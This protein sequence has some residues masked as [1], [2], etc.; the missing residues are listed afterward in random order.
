MKNKFMVIIIAS[1]LTV[2]GISVAYATGRDNST[3][4]DFNRQIMRSQ[5]SNSKSSYNYISSMMGDD[6]VIGVKSNGSYE[7]MIKTM[8]DNGFSDEAKAMGNRDFSSMDN[9]MNNISDNDYQKMIDIM[10]ES[11]YGSMVNMMNSLGR[12]N[13]TEIHKS[14]MEN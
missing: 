2:G 13:M 6:N 4:N 9:L 5:N 11:G 8:K 1:I 12:K 14:M 10:E 3:D 7:D